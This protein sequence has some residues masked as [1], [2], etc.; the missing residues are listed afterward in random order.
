MDYDTRIRRLETAIQQLSNLDGIDHVCLAPISSSDWNHSLAKTASE[1]LFER[2]DTFL[3]YYDQKYSALLTVLRTR[4][5]TL[6]MEKMSSYHDHARK[7]V[8]IPQAERSLYVTTTK[9]DPSV[10]TMLVKGGYV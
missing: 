4:K 3:L 6:E 10:K 1:D 9:I 7:L 8:G 2:L 5:Q